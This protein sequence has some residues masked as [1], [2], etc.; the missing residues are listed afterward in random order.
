MP[1]DQLCG[2]VRDKVSV[3]FFLPSPL[4]SLWQETGGYH[5]QADHP[6]KH[7]FPI[8]FFKVLQGPLFSLQVND[9]G[10]MHLTPCHVTRPV[11][12]SVVP[13]ARFH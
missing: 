5:E 8:G 10:P 3:L 11:M 6:S 9:Y 12:Y 4:G 7:G 2:T 13:K 1:S